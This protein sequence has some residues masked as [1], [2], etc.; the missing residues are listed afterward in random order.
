M[1]NWCIH[2]WGICPN[3][4]RRISACSVTQNSAV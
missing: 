4:R 1:R 3:L 2:T